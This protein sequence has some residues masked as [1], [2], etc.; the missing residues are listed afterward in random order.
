MRARGEEGRRLRG[1]GYADVVIGAPLND[2]AGQDAGRAYVCSGKDG[3]ILL[4]LTG[5]EAGDR[6]GAAVAGA[7]DKHHLFILV[8][9]PS[10]GPSHSGRT[11][12]YKSLTGKPA[13]VMITD[14]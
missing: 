10:A 6:F 2:A 13:F 1:D 8:G 9:A 3:S 7:R 5:E 12:A 14:T 4:T 11:Y